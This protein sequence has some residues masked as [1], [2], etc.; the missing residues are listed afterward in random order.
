MTKAHDAKVRVMTH[1]FRKALMWAGVA[2][3]TAT[4]LYSCIWYAAAV[5]LRQQAK[6][7]FETQQSQSLTITYAQPTL[8]GFPGRIG[9]N[10]AGFSIAAARIGDTA[11]WSWRSDTLRLFLRPFAF[12]TVH[13]DLGGTHILAGVHDAPLLLTLPHGEAGFTFTGE[14]LANVT[15]DISGLSAAWQ[16]ETAPYVGVEKITAHVAMV[17]A[18]DGARATSRATFSASDVTLPDI[19]PEGLSRTLQSVAMTLDLHGP[20]TRGPL[21]QAL[22]AWRSAGGD[23]DVRDFTAV[24]PPVTASGSGTVALDDDLQPIGAFTAKFQGFLDVVDMLVAQGR[25]AAGEATVARGVLSLLAK[26]PGGGGAPELSLAVTAQD[27]TVFAG[28]ITLMELPEIVWPANLVV[29]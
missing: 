1:S 13:A 29:P 21:P 15:V 6:A 10:F 9:V 28:P 22:D 18:P 3:L 26:T 19:L 7:W 11:G 23:I 17:A 2:A 14:R 5:L 25:M 16:N 4:L 24:W 12:R 20:I 8:S 27:R